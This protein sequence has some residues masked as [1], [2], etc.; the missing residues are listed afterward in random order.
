M[1]DDL[2]ATL[3]ALLHRELPVEDVA[4][5]FAAPDDHFP[6]SGV[7]PP[8]IGFFL[9]DIQE[10]RDL[11]TQRFEL[12]R[13]ADG[14][15][16]RTRTPV[17]VDCS[18]LITA[19]PSGSAPHPAADEHRLLG[20]VMKVLLRHPQIPAEYLQGELVDQEPPARS[21]LLAENQLRSLGEFW[22][23]M[24]GKPKAA[25]QYAVTVGFDVFEP[26]DVGPRVTAPVVRVGLDPTQP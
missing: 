13:R 10:N 15:T 11:R 17:R 8:A 23:A 5:S 25:L 21:R 26:V 3:A 20:A 2:D 12:D 14:T 24:G 7:E 22:Q 9:Y 1:F 6:P 19:W 18:Y 16:T 4:I